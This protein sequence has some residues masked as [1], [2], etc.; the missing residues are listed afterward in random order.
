MGLTCPGTN[1]QSTLRQR[2][3]AVTDWGNLGFKWGR[4][5]VAQELLVHLAILDSNHS[6]FR[7]AA[8]LAD[9]DGHAE[10]PIPHVEPK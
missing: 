3:Q 10:G 5:A 7:S 8:G 2:A 9:L 1:E 4:V 6:P